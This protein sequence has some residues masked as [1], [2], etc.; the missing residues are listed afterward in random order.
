MSS[1][2]LAECTYRAP[3]SAA[4]RSQRTRASSKSAPPSSTVA[5]NARIAAFFSG[6]LPAGTN[7]VQAT[8]FNRAARA[9]DWP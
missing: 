4:C 5:P 6:L 9:I 7:T 8:P 3:V 1:G 2:S